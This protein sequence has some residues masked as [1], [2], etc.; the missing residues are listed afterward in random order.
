MKVSNRSAIYS[1]LRE[2]IY[3][4]L[5]PIIIIPSSVL[6]SPEE[7]T[8]AEVYCRATVGLSPEEFAL[9]KPFDDTHL[10]TATRRIMKEYAYSNA[11][12]VTFQ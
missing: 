9:I 2:R 12:N 7:A 4:V 11:H 5:E 10:F 8:V 6:E 1:M 3:E